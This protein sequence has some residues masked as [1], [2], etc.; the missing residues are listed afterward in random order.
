MNPNT[1]NA[2]GMAIA[3]MVLGIVSIPMLCCSGLGLPLAAL[4]I[5]FAL[6][7]R[8]GRHMST[9]AKVGFGLSLGSIIITFLAFISVLVFAISSD[10]VKKSM[11]I[12]LDMEINLDEYTTPQE[13]QEY[14]QEYLEEQ[15]GTDLY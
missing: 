6:L 8:R 9:Q 1:T 12:I 11:D 4:G 15:L 3:A 2:N 5:I 7:S 10:E 14:V 13:I